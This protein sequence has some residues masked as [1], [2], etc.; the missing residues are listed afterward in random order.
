MKK[1]EATVLLNELG[2][3]NLVDPNLVLIEHNGPG[4]YRL[5]IRGDYDRAKITLFIRKRELSCKIKDNYLTI[6]RL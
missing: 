1:E 5:Q 2:A 3:H 6:S 4:R